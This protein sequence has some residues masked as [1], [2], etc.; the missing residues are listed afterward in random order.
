MISI[1]IPAYNA[2]ATIDRCINSIDTAKKKHDIE[3][4]IINDGSK[5]ETANLID[6]WAS[7]KSWITIISQ[8]NQGLSAARNVGLNIVQ[9]DHIVFIDADDT[10]DDW[11]FDFIIEKAVLPKVDMLV[12]GHKRMMLDGSIIEKKNTVAEY[13][14]KD[15]EQLQLRV[16]ENRNIYW[17]AWSRVYSKKLIENLRFDNDVKFGEDSIFHI[18]CLNK[19]SHLIVVADCPY[20]YYENSSSLTSSKYKPNLLESIESHYNARVAAH[21]WP[22]SQND[23]QILLSDFARSYVEHMLPYLLNNLIYLDSKA[24]RKELIKIRE[25]F[26]YE[27]CISNYTHRHPARGIR[28]LISCFSQRRYMMTLILLQLIWYKKGKNNA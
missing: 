1:I 21:I 3:V 12:F 19:A 16:T 20:N 23:R 24:R 4:I 5:D 26:V 14:L 9:G 18:K 15:I 22:K 8:E 27:E 7:I 25:S 11:Y 10:I 6:K 28:T 17:Y 2:A 13:T